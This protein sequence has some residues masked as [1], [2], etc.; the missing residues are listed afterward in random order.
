[1]KKD[2]TE[3]KVGEAGT[4]VELCGNQGFLKRI[5]A[6]GIR[7][8]KEIQKVS[9]QVWQGPITVK[10]DNFQVALGFGMA[11]KIIVEVEENTPRISTNPSRINTN[12]DSR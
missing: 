7:E 2:L 11:K 10:I 9:S 3:L 5:C 1:M 8:G 6:L 12:K 4:I